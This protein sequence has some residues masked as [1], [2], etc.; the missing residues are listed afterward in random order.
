MLQ[1]IQVVCAHGGRGK[2]VHWGAG[3]GKGREGGSKTSYV[4]QETDDT[5]LEGPLKRS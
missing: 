5:K 2:E 3:R 1:Y 4:L